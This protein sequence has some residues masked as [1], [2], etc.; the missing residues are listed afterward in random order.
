M[1]STTPRHPAK[2]PLMIAITVVTLALTL[3]VLAGAGNAVVYTLAAIAMAGVGAVIY[4]A[5]NK[6]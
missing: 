3:A 1:A 2:K 5:Q 4:L 6:H